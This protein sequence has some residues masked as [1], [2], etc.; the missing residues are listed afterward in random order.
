M[1][2]A[3][4]KRARRIVPIFLFMVLFTVVFSAPASAAGLE[5]KAESYNGYEYTE[6]DSSYYKLDFVKQEEGWFGGI[7]ESLAAGVNSISDALWTLSKTLSGFT[8]SVV[9]E[10]YKLEFIKLFASS[11]G[12]NIQTLSGVDETGISANGLLYGFLLLIILILGFYVVY[13]GLLKRQMSRVMSMTLNFLLVFALSVS[14]LGYAPLYME[15]LADFASDFNISVL[16]AGAKLVYPDGSSSAP[17]G[18]DATETIVN[19]LWGIQVKMPWMIL[20]FGTADVEAV[21]V[22]A[23]LVDPDSDD[24]QDA[25]ENEVNGYDN[26]NMTSKR[27][28]ERFGTVLLILIVN[29]V[30][31]VFV[32]LLMGTMVFSEILFI[33]YATMLPFVLI[34]GMIPG[35]SGKIMQSVVQLFNALLT[36]TAIS[37]I[38]TVAFSISSM[39]YSLTQE[40]YF[41]FIVFLQIV[42]FAGIYM[43]I[44]RLLR[45]VSLDV[46]DSQRFAGGIMHGTK[47]KYMQGKH[48]LRVAGH[49]IA[50]TRRRI[51]RAV[52]KNGSKQGT[53]RSRAAAQDESRRTT[54]QNESRRGNEPDSKQ[55]P[56]QHTQ[57]QEK[58]KTGNAPSTKDK[59]A[60][61]SALAERKTDNK[62]NTANAA[63]KGVPTGRNPSTQKAGRNNTAHKNMDSSRKQETPD[64][65]QGQQKTVHSMKNG[66]KGKKGPNT[67]K[68]YVSGQVPGKMR[69]VQRK[70]TVLNR[71]AVQNS[72]GKRK[73]QLGNAGKAGIPAVQQNKKQAASTGTANRDAKVWREKNTKRSMQHSAE[74]VYTPKNTNTARERQKEA[75]TQQARQAP[76]TERGGAQENPYYRD[77]T[78]DRYDY[79]PMQPDGS[80]KVNGKAYSRKQLKEVDIDTSK[81]AKKQIQKGNKVKKQPERRLKR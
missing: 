6:Y 57:N 3:S 19:N 55:R 78:N 72:T 40:T 56:V 13:H 43:N 67:A 62:G 23:L 60:A 1:K 77:F 36:R 50:S 41:L 74:K 44:S 38:V 20:E 15:K 9:K 63:Q 75:V 68:Q 30:I 21:R 69:V 29:L 59:N 33:I 45:F 35:M 37:L 34:F 70:K 22:E 61:K 65:V 48:A 47:R 49:G 16:N 64:T 39:F 18:G 76:A 5:E 31:S 66:S 4:I 42:T 53:Q 8:G 79:R 71:P 81:P 54:A 32:I 25:A 24:R 12:E 10:V 2:R 11:I 28:G 27:L 14:F 17:D 26:F 80:V 52:H 73:F 7:S 58:Q 46:G 51:G